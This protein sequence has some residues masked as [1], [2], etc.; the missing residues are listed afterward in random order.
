MVEQKFNN[1]Y[2]I[3]LYALSYLLDRFEQKDQLFAVQCNWW[4]ASITQFTGTLMFYRRYRIF[5]SDYMKNSVVTPLDQP[6]KPS[7]SESN[8]SK[9]HLELNNSRLHWEL[10]MD[11][12]PCSI[13]RELAEA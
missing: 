1:K 10:D 4:L 3:I 6:L 13:K 9:L 5:T 12:H 8:I 2:N 11:H 7:V